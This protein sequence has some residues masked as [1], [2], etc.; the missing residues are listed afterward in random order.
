MHD[1]NQILS[2]ENNELKSKLARAE[3]GMKG[4]KFSENE[5][6]LNKMLFNARRTIKEKEKELEHMRLQL[7]GKSEGSGQSIGSLSKL[8]EAKEGKT[9]SD[10]YRGNVGTRNFSKEKRVMSK[11]AQKY[12]TKDDSKNTAAN[13]CVNCKKLL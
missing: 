6:N 8:A 7:K 13:S 4:S 10:K 12:R 9:E 3:D 1:K 5:K 11:S 2:R